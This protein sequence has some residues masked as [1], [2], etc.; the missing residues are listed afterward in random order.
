[1]SV[2]ETDDGRGL[3]WHEAVAALRE[4]EGKQVAVRIARHV[5][6]E[7]LIAVFHGRLGAMDL[8]AKQPSL[9]WPLDGPDRHP[10][11]PGLYLYEDDFLGG[12]RRAG[13]IVVIKQG[14]VIVNVRPLPARGGG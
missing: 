9:F 11:R 14:D 10:E 2:E 7:K 3:D 5:V 13:G 12:E 8:D 1:M 6:D 4:L